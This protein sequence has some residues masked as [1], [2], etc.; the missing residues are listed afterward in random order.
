VFLCFW[1]F[2]VVC[3]VLGWFLGIC[4]GVF[5]FL[6]CSM[7]FVCV[8]FVCLWFCLLGVF[9]FWLFVLVLVGGV[10]VDV[11]VFSDFDCYF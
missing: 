1:V 6:F 2:Y 8:F 3:G 5:V 9:V 11:C 4:V 10:L 7:G